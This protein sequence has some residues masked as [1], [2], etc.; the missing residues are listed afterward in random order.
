MPK[1]VKKE[2]E[3]EEEE[4]ENT[5]FEC[6]V[7]GM[8]IDIAYEQEGMHYGYCDCC[9]DNDKEPICIEHLDECDGCG[10]YGCACFTINR[11]NGCGHN[12]C[13]SCIGI[14]NNENGGGCRLCGDCYWCEDCLQDG[15]CETC[16]S[17]EQEKQEKA[18]KRQQRKLRKFMKKKQRQ[19]YFC[20]NLRKK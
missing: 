5:R 8:M 10:T 20:R 6:I 16:F 17:Q 2:I 19:I 15:M 18:Q 1:K 13:E 14:D 12:Y 9:S 4:E 7:C 3:E 11:C